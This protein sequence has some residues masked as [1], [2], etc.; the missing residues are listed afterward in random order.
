MSTSALIDT[1]ESLGI[2]LAVDGDGLTYDAP[3]TPEADAFLA[4]LAER[5]D[6]VVAHLAA[7]AEPLP[8]WAAADPLIVRL[9][10]EGHTFDEAYAA[11]ERAAIEAGA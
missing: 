1:A 7:K 5:R 8:A 9:V 3:D 2:I 10:A 11:A 6:E 4:Q